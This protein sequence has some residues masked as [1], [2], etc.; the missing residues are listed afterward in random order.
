MDWEET[1]VSFWDLLRLTY[2][3]DFEA[4]YISSISGVIVG[5][6]WFTCL[7]FCYKNIL[8][9]YKN[10]QPTSVNASKV[11]HNI[12]YEFSHGAFFINSKYNAR[13]KLSC[14]LGESKCNPYWDMTL[15]TSRDTCHVLN[16]YLDFRQYGPYAIPS[17]DNNI[18]QLSCKFGE[19]NWNPD[20]VVALM[21]SF[22]TNYVFNDH[23]NLGQYDLCAIYIC[24][25]PSQIMPC[26]SYP[27]CLV[28]QNEISI[29]L[30]C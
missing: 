18:K 1:S 11:M 15:T 2:I 19:S 26:Y 10:P 23:E 16:E 9:T 25:I 27:S 13:L 7:N 28:N 21:N 20:W 22:G 29:D 6:H 30:S 12:N 24:E 17:W 14:K 8:E 3:R 4:Y 5:K